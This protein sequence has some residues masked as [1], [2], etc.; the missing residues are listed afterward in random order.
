[1]AMINK[2]IF[3]IASL[4]VLAVSYAYAGHVAPW[5]IDEIMGKELPAFSLKDI[6]ENTVTQDLLKG[7]AG[8]INFW[9]TWCAP[10]KVEM[11]SLN[12]LYAKLRDKGFEVLAVSIDDSDEPV[13]QFLKDHPLDFRV[14]RDGKADVAVKYKVFAYPT[15]FLID[16]KGII[17][18]KYIGETD[19][20]DPEVLQNI[21]KI[22]AE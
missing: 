20:L 2:S 3:L 1:M 9:A 16:R 15:T 6:S 19:W 12:T 13:I 11:P 22:L 21:E 5:E 10:C 14:L 17:R 18:D 4:L 8:L 7:K